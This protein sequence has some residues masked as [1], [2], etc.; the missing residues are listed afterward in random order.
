MK[1]EYLILY[2]IADMFAYHFLSNDL[3]KIDENG[4]LVFIKDP[5]E[6]EKAER[7]I[8]KMLWEILGIL[9]KNLTREAFLAIKKKYENLLNGFAL[10]I[11][12]ILANMLQYL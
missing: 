2:A 11:A 10:K 7:R 8:Y 9:N 12:N 6:F 4:D 3:A 5:R 1:N